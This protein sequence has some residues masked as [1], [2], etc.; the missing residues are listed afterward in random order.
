MLVE[1]LGGT[2]WW[3]SDV[4]FGIGLSS[5]EIVWAE[6]PE[7]KALKLKIGQVVWCYWAKELRIVTAIIPKTDCPD[8]NQLPKAEPIEVD[9]K[10]W[11]S[12]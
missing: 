3:I 4:G 6:T 1:I 2:V 10:S 7:F 9:A 8:K 11:G 5:G 12:A